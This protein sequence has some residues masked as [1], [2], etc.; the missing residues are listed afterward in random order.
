MFDF[1]IR[2]EYFKQKDKKLEQYRDSMQ[3]KETV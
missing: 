1:G 2:H 3:L